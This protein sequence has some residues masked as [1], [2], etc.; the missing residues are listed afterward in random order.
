MAS[1]CT[2][3][4]S[5]TQSEPTAVPLDDQGSSWRL[6]K[7]GWQDSSAWVADTFAPQPTLE[8]VHPV[9]WAMLV[10]LIVLVATIWACSEWEYAQ[11]FRQ[12]DPQE[13]ES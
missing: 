7:F 6:T 9:V 11:L 13:D 4:G 10:L 12:A 5:V 3:A 8:L 2:L 1:V